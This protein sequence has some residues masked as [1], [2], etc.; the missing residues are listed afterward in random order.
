MR[1]SPFGR[2]ACCLGLLLMIQ[3]QAF[4]QTRQ[5]VI[6]KVE[7][8][9]SMVSHY[10]HLQERINFYNTAGSPAG[11]TNYAIPHLVYDPVVTL[12][13]PYNEALTLTKAR[14]KISDPPVGFAFKKNNVFLRP[15]FANG[16]FIGLP[17]F[18]IAHEHDASARKSFTLFL[19][20][21]NA[22]GQ[23]GSS[24][25]LQPGQ[26]RTFSAWVEANWTWG[27][28]TAGG[29]TVRSFFDW[30]SSNDFTNR[31]GRTGNAFGVESIPGPFPYLGDAR[32]GFQTDGLSLSTRPA[33]TRYDFETANNWGGN[34]V[35]IKMNDSVTVEAKAMRT[36]PASSSPDFQVELL[37]GQV[38]DPA[39]DRVKAFPMSI[40][41]I[42]Q[43]PAQPIVSRTYRVGDILQGPNDNT[44]GGKSPFASV[45]LMAK[46]KALQRNTFYQ[47][48]AV[49]TS[50]L[51]EIRFDEVVQFGSILP[52]TS[53]API[54]APEVTSVTRNGDTL[55]VDFI[56]R[57]EITSW[58]LK[59]TSSL[60]AGFDDTLTGVM[61]G[62]SGTGVHKAIINIAGRGD[63]YFVRI[64]E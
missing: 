41:N 34:W 28:E 46:T 18:Q 31:D 25:V 59:G 56:G 33:A 58:K 48:P 39:A 63:R 14:V 20:G 43:H 6:S 17:R 9:F 64:E 1:S 45:T 29:Y 10:N 7:F 5:P 52:R 49:P 26:S 21:T 54:G 2:A 50:D 15:E 55:Y 62:P 44:S 61:A 42:I 53:D 40:S 19:R 4:A 23:P 35:A 57:P 27:L 36:F 11:N 38:V 12:Y 8:L 3:S 32:A 30:N 24:I 22:S 37:K 60:Q 47:T 16:S 51:Y 13:N